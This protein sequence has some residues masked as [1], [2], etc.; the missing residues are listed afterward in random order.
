MV[1]SRFSSWLLLLPLAVAGCSRGGDADVTPA[2]SDDAGEV[3]AEPDDDAAPPDDAAQDAIGDEPV[4]PDEPY[5]PGPLRVV[6]WNTHDFYDDVAGN[7]PGCSGEV[8]ESSAAYTQKLTGVSQQLGKLAG[9]VVML[10]EIENAGVLDKLAAAPAIATLKYQY[11]TLLP[12]RDPCRHV[13]FMSRYPI[14]GAVSHADDEF[15]RVDAPA[16]AY[17][18]TRDCLEIHMTYRGV[19]LA[20]LGVH[21][22]SKTDPDDP[23]RRLAEAQRARQIADSVLLGDP[24]AYVFIL[25]DFNDPEGSATALAVQNGQSGPQYT[26]APSVLPQANRY[27]YVY[28]SQMSLIDHLFASPAPAG[29]LVSNAVTIP[30]GTMPSD[31]DPIAATYQVP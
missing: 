2:P 13:G 10:E 3:E 4:V 6:T 9:D 15:T 5:A 26:D 17:H 22:K 28:Q 29:R 7:S 12:G 11:R 18:F 21:F 27:T 23:D 25:G 1:E 20:L 24:S 19:H 8:V 16:A 14:D 31:H 30:H